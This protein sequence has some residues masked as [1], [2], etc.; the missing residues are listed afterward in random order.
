[1]EQ[2]H[3]SRIGAGHWLKD[4][5]WHEGRPGRVQCS[6]HWSSAVEGGYGQYSGGST[7]EV[8]RRHEWSSVM[9]G[10]LE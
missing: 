7:G 6:E 5:Q 8:K 4:E 1:M 3:G 9:E 10:G 2:C